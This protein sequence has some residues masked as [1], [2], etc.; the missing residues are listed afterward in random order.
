M[1]TNQNTYNTRVTDETLEKRFRDTF[2][3][4]GGAE[5][6]SDLYAQGVIVPIVDFTAAAE[7]SSLREDLQRS[8]DFST[9]NS[10]VSNTTTTIINTTGFWKIWGTW[11]GRNGGSNTDS[12]IKIS[13]SLATK[14]I[15]RLEAQF[16]AASDQYFGQNIPEMVVF[17]RAG[18]SVQVFSGNTDTIISVSYRQ[19]A[20]VSGNLTNPLG[21]TSS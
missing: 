15:W 16:A 13:D 17:L 6:V 20:D 14:T 1:P 3:S 8:W 18:D 12:D 10:N 9:G 19:I 7:G 21:F 4:Q 5:L 2:T 11:S